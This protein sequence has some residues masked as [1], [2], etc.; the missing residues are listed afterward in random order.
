MPNW[1]ITLSS[2]SS[3]CTTMNGNEG[4]TIAIALVC[5]RAI[6]WRLGLIENERAKGK[7]DWNERDIRQ[8]THSLITLE[9]KSLIV[10]TH[11]GHCIIR[12]LPII[13]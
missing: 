12:S 2:S 11:T 1:Q 6:L 13:T 10:S 9:L 4:G 8:S 7:T 3:S 5:S